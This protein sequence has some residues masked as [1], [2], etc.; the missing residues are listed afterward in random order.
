[1]MSLKAVSGVCVGAQTSH[2]SF[3]MSAVQFIV[4][5]GACAWNGYS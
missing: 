5:S 3:R 1:M 2:D 4:S